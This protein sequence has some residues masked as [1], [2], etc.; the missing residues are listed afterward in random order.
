MELSD[1]ESIRAL[2]QGYGNPT[3]ARLP[4]G[5][6]NFA[7]PANPSNKARKVRCKCG[8][9]RQCLEDARWERIFAEKFADP[10]YYTRPIVTRASPLTSH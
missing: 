9:C 2:M 8:H 7:A 6:Q 10:T 4:R 5:E 3:T 1:P